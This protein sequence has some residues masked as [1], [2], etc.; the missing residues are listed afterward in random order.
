[1]KIPFTVLEFGYYRNFTYFCN[2]FFRLLQ[3]KVDKKCIDD[4]V[5]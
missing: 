5:R 3:D 2:H 4:F 1:V